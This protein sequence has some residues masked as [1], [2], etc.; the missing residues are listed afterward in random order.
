M[1][2]VLDHEGEHP[3]RWAAIMSISAKFGRDAPGAGHRCIAAERILVA[4]VRGIWCCPRDRLACRPCFV[5]AQLPSTAPSGLSGE[6]HPLAVT[7]QR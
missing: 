6:K 4:R 1:R 2:M 3:S 7:C 5:S